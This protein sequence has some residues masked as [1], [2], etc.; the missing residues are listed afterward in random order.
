MIKIFNKTL[1]QYGK[2]SL[3]FVH[4]VEKKLKA[5]GEASRKKRSDKNHVF[6]RVAALRVF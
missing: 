2:T 3:F 4:T 6:L 1:K 5:R